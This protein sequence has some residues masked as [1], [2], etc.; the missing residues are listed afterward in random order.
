MIIINNNYYYIYPHRY[1]YRDIICYYSDIMNFSS[2]LP[3][4]TSPSVFSSCSSCS[5][6]WVPSLF[7]WPPWP[8]RRSEAPKVF[9]DLGKL[10]FFSWR[11]HMYL[12][13]YIYT[14]IY[15]YNIY[16]YTHI[17]MYIYII[18]IYMY[19]IYIYIYVYNI[20]YIYICIIYIY[21]Y[22]YYIYILYYI[23][24]IE[25]YLQ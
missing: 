18:Y 17:Y 12:P 2:S 5:S 25:M 13:I 7:P 16:I 1:F 9:W 6:L 4:W 21:I 3:R 14:Y 15:V 19:I 10:G 23:I 20:I 24:Y 8:R 11:S 22:V